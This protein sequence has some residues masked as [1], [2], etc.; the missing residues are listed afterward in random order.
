MGNDMKIN[1]AL[2]LLKAHQKILGKERENLRDLREKIEDQENNAA[3]ALDDL[4]ACIEK[5]SELV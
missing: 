4:N 1:S 2:K 3:D 5:L